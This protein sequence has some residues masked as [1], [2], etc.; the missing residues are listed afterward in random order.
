[1]R[2]HA[3]FA[4]EY[5]ATK[6]HEIRRDLQRYESHGWQVDEEENI[7]DAIMAHVFTT[8]GILLN[9]DALV[10]IFACLQV[11]SSLFLLFKRYN[12]HTFTRAKN[13][14]SNV[15]F[16]NLLINGNTNYLVNHKLAFIN[17]NFV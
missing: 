14:L 10:P 5:G 2:L 7:V 6:R 15:H 4:K 17:M 3:R 8:T 11:N 1:M 12:L 9:D 13:I 16:N